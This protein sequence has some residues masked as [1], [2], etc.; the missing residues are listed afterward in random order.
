MG[1]MESLSNSWVNQQTH[2]INFQPDERPLVSDW[3]SVHYQLKKPFFQKSVLEPAGLILYS[4]I[5]AIITYS[6]YQND[7]LVGDHV[8]NAL[9][10]PLWPM[11]FVMYKSP[12]NYLRAV[13]YGFIV[14]LLTAAAY[15]SGTIT[16]EGNVFLKFLVFLD[17]ILNLGIRQE[18][19]ANLEQ[20]VRLSLTLFMVFVVFGFFL[21]ILHA[22]YV[23]TF[24]K[25]YL[26]LK[27]TTKN[28]YLR[29]KSKT[30][31]FDLVKQ[32]IIILFSPF[33]IALYSSIYRQIKHQLSRRIEGDQYEFAKI[34]VESVKS[35]KKKYDS[36][37]KRICFGILMLLLGIIFLQFGI[38]LF[39]MIIGLIMICRKKSELVGIQIKYKRSK[40]EGSLLMLTSDSILNLINV[41]PD[42]AAHFPE[43]K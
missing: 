26:E 25:K 13:I 37:G 21:L 15:Q 18:L 19:N 4:I 7:P 34:G 30:T 1:F 17:S 24:G 6:I 29:R 11:F 40:V 9:F 23:K 2:E 27:I 3:V 5:Y 22:I 38:G 8:F 33:N 20:A 36:R 10:F 32:A 42:I 41:Q 14:L 16:A 35:I 31:K 39:F 43:V 28:V 12:D